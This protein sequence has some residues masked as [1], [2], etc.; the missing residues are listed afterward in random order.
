MFQEFDDQ[1]PNQRALLA[2]LGDQ[3]TLPYQR[4]GSPAQPSSFQEWVQANP[5]PQMNFAPAQ[6]AGYVDQ[7]RRRAASPE[8]LD[9]SRRAEEAAAGFG[10]GPT[11]TSPGSAN[12]APPNGST[13]G[14]AQKAIG[15]YAGKLEGFGGMLQDGRSK[16][17]HG[18]SP[19]Y[20]FARVMS[21]FDP[22][23]GISQAMLDELN[24]LGLGSV[25]G[26]IGGDKISI[27]GNVDPR[28][29]GLTEFDV[30]RDLENG[31][32]WQWGDASGGGGGQAP[33]MAGNMMPGSGGLNTLLMGDPL[34]AIQAAIGQYQQPSSNLQAL[35]DQLGGR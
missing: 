13:Q 34:A 22:K 32:G 23:G 30:I 6:G 3:H 5:A 14:S 9:W 27:G 16:L 29:N 33:G 12:F 31:G 15:Q 35:I 10:A 4:G 7:L 18:D 11:T 26:K 2:Q 19:K 8:V 25:S 20:Q 24:K 28:F 1:R 17:E 21:N